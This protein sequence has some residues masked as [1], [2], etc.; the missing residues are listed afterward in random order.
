[1][2]SSHAVMMLCSLLQV[3]G[4]VVTESNHIEVV[5]LIKSKNFVIYIIYIIVSLIK[6]KNSFFVSEVK[7]KNYISVHQSVVA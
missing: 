6:S 1:M 4:T 2:L 5:S 3:N 7:S